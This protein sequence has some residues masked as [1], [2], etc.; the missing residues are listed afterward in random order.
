MPA[1]SAPPP[2]YDELVPKLSLG[3]CW[4]RPAPA[5]APPEP[6][7]PVRELRRWPLPRRSRRWPP[8][9][10]PNNQIRRVA[11]VHLARYGSER[12]LGDDVG[13][14]GGNDLR[15]CI[16]QGPHQVVTA[17]SDPRQVVERAKAAGA[18]SVLGLLE[19][20]PEQNIRELMEAV[21]A[22]GLMFRGVATADVPKRSMAVDIIVDMMLLPHEA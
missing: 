5:P 8:E 4:L 11:V 15:R 18:V 14:G 19:G 3:P 13:Q 1:R 7:A 17:G 12:C 9:K 20:L 6:V 2:V 21:A 10:T 22:A 16:A